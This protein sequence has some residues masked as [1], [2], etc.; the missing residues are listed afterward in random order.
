MLIDL[1]EQVYN[2]WNVPEDYWV[3]LTRFFKTD[4]ELF[5]SSSNV[6]QNLE[7]T[8][9]FMIQEV[10]NAIRTMR[11]NNKCIDQHLGFKKKEF[12]QSQLKVSIR[13]LAI[14]GDGGEP[15]A[16]PG[17]YSVLEE[18]CRSWD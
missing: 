7:W 18:V 9:N 2:I 12:I 17:T 8:E 13:M 11:S 6:K 3:G 10:L 1:C 4:K 5:D 16:V 14:T 15:T